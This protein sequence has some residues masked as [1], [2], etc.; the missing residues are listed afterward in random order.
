MAPGPPP[1]PPAPEGAAQGASQG[2]QTSEVVAILF[3]D[4]AQSSRLYETH[5]DKVAYGVIG[6]CLRLLAQSALINGGAPLKTAGDSILISFDDPAKAIQS[7][8]AMQFALMEEARFL[9]YGVTVKMGL[10]H[11]TVIVGKNDAWGDAVNIAWRLSEIASGGQIL[12]TPEILEA[13]DVEDLEVRLLGRKHVKGKDSK[14]TVFELMW[15]SGGMD[16]TH[17][18]ETT[19]QIVTMQEYLVLEHGGESWELSPANPLVEVGRAPKNHIQI[20]HKLVSKHHATIRFENNSF[21]IADHS[22]NGTYIYFDKAD[23]IYVHHDTCKLAGSG[24]ISPGKRGEEHWLVLKFKV[25]FPG[26]VSD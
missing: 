2:Q 20:A 19:G 21:N 9:P 11:G 17:V 25:G 22:T 26:T 24:V 14:I 3:A 6:G 16:T 23:P 8:V 4:I 13:A 15:N 1:P 10:H 7:A 12:L 18:V 5:G